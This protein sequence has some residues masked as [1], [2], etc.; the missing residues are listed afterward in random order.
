MRSVLRRVG[1]LLI[2]LTIS[3]L[4]G[5]IA[6]RLVHRV[7]P[8][9]IFY[10]ATYDRFRG[11]PGSDFRGHRLNDL[12]FNDVAFERDKGDR[13]RI[14]ALGDS[15]TF[16]IVPYPHNFLTLLEETLDQDH[17][18]VDVL[19]MGI[20]RTG[21]VEQLSLLLKEGLAY[22]PDLVLVSFFVGN[23]FLDVRRSMTKRR[24]LAERSFVMSLLRYA[25]V[26]RP[27]LEPGQVYGTRPYDDK[28][29]TFSERDFLRLVARR[30]VVFRTDWPPFP[31]LLER[32]VESL[33]DVERVCAQRGV[34]LSVVL[35]PEEVQ[36]SASL[37][38]ALIMA[39]ERYGSDNTDFERPNLLLHER[40]TDLGIDVLDLYPPFR[41]AAA[42]TRL[43][44]PRDTHWN[45]AGNRLASQLIASHLVEHGRLEAR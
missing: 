35:I 17:P 24:T 16:G 30:A 38:R 14:V 15:F 18:P 25:T 1:G 19:N 12:G 20:P 8:T 10:D 37:Q 41:E 11:E 45:I 23:D 3:F 4:V 33:Q 21:P 34:A 31:E 29:P 7:R 26:V 40:L 13:F 36:L 39:F 2:I 42:D 22:D 9:F 32:V 43:Y 5:E 27:S 6:L 44:K 28:A